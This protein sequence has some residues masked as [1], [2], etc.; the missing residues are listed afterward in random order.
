MLYLLT[1]N[2]LDDYVYL[3]KPIN[4]QGRIPVSSLVSWQKISFTS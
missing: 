2:H 1:L 3:S 4:L